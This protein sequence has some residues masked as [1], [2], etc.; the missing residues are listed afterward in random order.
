MSHKQTVIDSILSLQQ[1]IIMLHRDFGDHAVL[2]KVEDFMLK[3]DTVGMLDS[4]NING[5]EGRY[6]L[7]DAKSWIQASREM[8]IDVVPD[9][10]VWEESEFY[11]FL[12]HLLE[13]LKKRRKKQLVHS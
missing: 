10:V 9:F 11:S 6:F 12:E 3:L 8:D 1:H 13:P 2:K 7:I 4:I 5:K